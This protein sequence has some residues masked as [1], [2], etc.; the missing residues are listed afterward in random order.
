MPT[1]RVTPV[2]FPSRPRPAESGRMIRVQP[3]APVP[4]HVA[5]RTGRTM[6]EPKYCDIIMRGGITSGVVY[7]GAVV[8]LAKQGYTFKNVGGASAGAIAAAMT[9]AA[10]YA[11]SKG[12]ADPKAGF[13]G[14]DAMPS[15]FG[16]DAVD[17]SGRKN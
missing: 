17:K 7:P 2:T 15:W 4:I 12:S 14:I 6:P 11:K 9:A 10:Q 8:E 13:D 1:C 16:A 3:G 5:E